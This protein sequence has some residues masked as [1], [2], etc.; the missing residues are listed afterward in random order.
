MLLSCGLPLAQPTL[1]EMLMKLLSSF[2]CMDVINQHPCY[3]RAASWVVLEAQVFFS[4]ILS[5]FYPACI[6]KFLSWNIPFLFSEG[7]DNTAFVWGFSKSGFFFFFLSAK[8]VQL[9]HVVMLECLSVDFPSWIERQIKDLFN[10]TEQKLIERCMY[11]D[12]HLIKSRGGTTMELHKAAL[13]QSLSSKG[14]VWK[15]CW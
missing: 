1:H 13:C 7:S 14:S 5:L 12:S 11:K 15:S 6:G 9:L 8:L 10:H 2:T 3:W 4:H